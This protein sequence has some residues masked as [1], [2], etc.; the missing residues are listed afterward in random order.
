MARNDVRANAMPN[1]MTAAKRTPKGPAKMR[2][3]SVRYAD[4]GGAIVSHDMAPN[5]G[6]YMPDPQ[7]VFS[8]PAEVHAHIQS[9]YP[10]KGKRAN[11]Q[12][13]GE[14]A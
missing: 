7:H 6:P 13:P 10:A 14:Q 1:R 5:D 9:I 11:V 3:F 4:N 2:G 12:E 8:T